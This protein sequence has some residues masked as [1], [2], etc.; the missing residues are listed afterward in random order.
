MVHI[1]TITE[2]RDTR[3][4]LVELDTLLASIYNLVS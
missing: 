4:D 3:S 1:Q 2:S